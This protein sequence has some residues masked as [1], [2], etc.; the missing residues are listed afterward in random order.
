M[1][2]EIEELAKIIGNYCNGNIILCDVYKGLAE[3]IIEAG[4]EHKKC[5]N[6]D[7][8]DIKCQAK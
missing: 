2:K 7:H 4:Y 3:V 5:F 1:K 8:K 6:P